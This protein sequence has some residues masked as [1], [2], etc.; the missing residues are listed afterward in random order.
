MASDAARLPAAAAPSTPADRFTAVVDAYVKYRPSYPRELTE[1]VRSQLEPGATVVDLGAGTGIFSRALRDAGYRVIP[2]EPN[3]AMR[4]RCGFDEAVAGTAE[5]T[6]LPDGTARG[7]FAA[8]SAHWFDLPRAL[9]EM[10][11]IADARGALCAA[12][13]N[14]RAAHGFARALDEVYWKH[15]AEFR[16][17]RRIEPTL[18][19]LRALEPAGRDLEFAHAQSLD[20]DGVVGRSWS[21]SYVQHGVADRAAFD[22]DLEAAF[23]RHRDPATDTVALE[24]VARVFCWWVAPK[25]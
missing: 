19:E 24:Y 18:A 5:A 21:T 1:W 6:G 10:R 20:L 16:T 15:S 9:R 12:L 8:Q 25:P 17:L 13:W 11:R 23:N 3:A 14:D 22:A 7:V 2:V 4:E